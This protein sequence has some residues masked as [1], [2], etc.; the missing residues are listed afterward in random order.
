VLGMSLLGLVD[1][2]FDLRGRF[3]GSR[4]PPATLH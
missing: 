1:T 4:G 2:A 3:A